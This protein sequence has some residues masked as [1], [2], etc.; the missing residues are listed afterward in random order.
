MTTTDRGLLS[1]IMQEKPLHCLVEGERYRKF[2]GEYGSLDVKHYEFHRELHRDEHGYAYRYVKS[3]YLG[4]LSVDYFRGVWYVV[5]W[6][7][8]D[9]AVHYLPQLYETSEAACEA[10]LV[11]SDALLTE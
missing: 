6:K 9:G 3:K 8:G 2:V 7:A 11:I 10:M 5:W 1:R 4:M